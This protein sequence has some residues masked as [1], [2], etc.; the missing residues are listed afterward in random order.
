MDSS[1]ILLIYLREVSYHAHDARASPT[2][3]GVGGYLIRFLVL[4]LW[5]VN[6]LRERQF[7]VLYDRSLISWL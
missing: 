1:F 5:F 4:E 6:Y 2:R 7:V 3:G